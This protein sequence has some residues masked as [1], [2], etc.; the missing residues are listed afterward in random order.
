MFGNG[1]AKR[2]PGEP[3]H[4]TVESGKSN[5]SGLSDDGSSRLQCRPAAENKSGHWANSF[6]MK[7]VH[8]SCGPAGTARV[9]RDASP[10]AWNSVAGV[11]TVKARAGVPVVSLRALADAEKLEPDQGDHAH[12]HEPRAEPA[13]REAA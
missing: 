11:A 5:H 6:W 2:D 3:I 4:K 10:H 9:K 8:D 1:C 12:V 7:E 13:A